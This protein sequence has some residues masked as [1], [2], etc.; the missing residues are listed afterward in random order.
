[1]QHRSHTW[2]NSYPLLL[3]GLYAAV[4]IP[5]AVHPVSRADWL[6]ENLLVF[7]FVP[8]GIMTYRQMRFSNAAY[9]CFCIFFLV[10]AVGAHYTY[11]LVPY[12][13]WFE[14]WIGI[15]PSEVFSFK[16]NH[17]D[18]VVH[19]LYGV[20]IVVPSA[21]LLD[22]FARPRSGWRIALP[23][24]FVMS[25]SVIY[26]VVEWIAAVVFA[27]DLGQAYLGTQGDEWDA[28]EDM[29]LAAVGAVVGIMSLRF[30]QAG[31]RS[32]AKVLTTGATRNRAATP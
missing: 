20:L 5:L 26:E 6:L 1:M 30:L 3:L 22:R 21:E 25:H 18:R 8:V 10:H 11:S 23:V 14:S 24:L 28:Q 7:I 17:F 32:N 19:L 13:T 9:T 2:T 4:W 29:A 27:G 12:D 31:A 15:T 16:R